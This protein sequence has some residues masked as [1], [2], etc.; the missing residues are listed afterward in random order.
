MRWFGRA[1]PSARSS[2]WETAG[3]RAAAEGRPLRVLVVRQD[4]RLGNLVLLVPFLRSLRD[5]LPAAH[6]AMVTGD[7]YADLVRGWPWVNEWIVQPKRL[8]ATRPWLFPGWLR[9]LRGGNWD[10]AFEMSNHN[11]HSYYNCVL[12]VASGAPLRVGFDEPRN[13]DALT[14]AVPPPSDR[15]PF[16]LAPLRLLSETGLP[17]TPSAPALPT[18]GPPSSR[19][20][21]WSEREL[22]EAA[23]ALIHVGGRGGK[24]WPLE[25][26][27]RLV[28]KARALGGPRI[29]LIGG[30]DEIDRMRALESR[31]AEPGNGGGPAPDHP[32]ELVAPMFDVRDLSHLIRGASYYLGCDTGVMH[33]AASVGTP[34]IALFFRSNPT[35]YAPLGD[36]HRTVILADPYEAVSRWNDPLPESGEVTRSRL[37]VA[38]LDADRSRDGVP[39]TG[40]DADDA[41]VSAIQDLFAAAR[42]G[43]VG[44]S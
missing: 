18:D 22:G 2:L 1:Q 25:S 42:G 21:E 12:T 11:T 19:F 8:H 6:I 41:I 38:P 35:H 3:A 13:A 28:P 43:P 26:W 40:E 15:V 20:G 37:F 10:V 4:N 27:T 29:V 5:A 44:V 34:T 32:P 33:L 17:V 23:Y 9:T 7:E 14:H 31:S 16:A 24:S 39:A 36:A 30:P